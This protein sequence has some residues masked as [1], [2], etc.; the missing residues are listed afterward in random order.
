MPPFLSTEEQSKL[1]YI[2]LTDTMLHP[3]KISPHPPFNSTYSHEQVLKKT[4]PL[5][6]EIQEDPLRS[7]PLQLCLA[8]QSQSHWDNGEESGITQVKV[9][10][11]LFYLNGMLPPY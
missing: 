6:L 10:G 1:Q 3:H 4:H 9:F 5:P 8:S 11:F 7:E 2:S